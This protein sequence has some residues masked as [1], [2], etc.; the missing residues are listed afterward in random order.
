MRRILLLIPLLVIII[1]V[2][3][4]VKEPGSPRWET[5]VT[6]PI[7]GKIYSMSD[8]IADST[9]PE[10]YDSIGTWF[11][12]S[13][14][15]MFVNY[16]DSIE[17][18][19]NDDSL[20]ADSA[21]SLRS[22]LMGP[23]VLEAP[24]SGT[25]IYLVE[26]LNNSFVPGIYDSIPEFSADSIYKELPAYETFEWMELIA[27][28]D[29][30]GVLAEDTNEVTINITNNCP[31]P[32]DLISIEL[33]G[34]EPNILIYEHIFD[35]FLAS[36][37]SI[38]Y[39]DTL[40]TGQVIDNEM[41]LLVSGHS[42][43]LN[44]PTEITE[45]NNISFDVNLSP[46]TVFEAV[47]EVPAQP[48]DS[49][50]VF[51]VESEDTIITATFK[52]AYMDYQ[53]TDLTGIYNDVT[54]SMPGMTDSNGVA[55]DTT[56]ELPPYGVFY[57]E[58]IPI[59]GYTFTATNN[60]IDVYVDAFIKDSRN[61]Q[62]YDSSLVHITATSG[63]DVTVHIYN[64]Y[65]DDHSFTFKSFE[66]ILEQRIQEIEPT[67]QEI[68]DIPDGLDSIDVAIATLDVTLYS[69]LGAD[70]PVNIEIR[71]YRKDILKE[72]LFK[73]FTLAAGGF[74]NPVMTKVS[75]P[76]AEQI[77]NVVPDK[78]EVAGD[79]IIEG[80]VSMSEEDFNDAYVEGS[81]I[82]YSPMSLITGLTNMQA[83]VDTFTSG[84]DN[85]ILEANLDLNIES[86]VPLDGIVS[87]LGS[88]NLDAFDDSTSTEVDTLFK[89]VELPQ[90]VLNETTGYVVESGFITQQRTLV[91][92]QFELFANA[93]EE[94]PF[95]TKLYI[96]T[97]PT[98]GKVVNF[99]PNDYI[100]VGSLGHFLLDI[101]PEELLGER[102]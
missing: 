33:W 2:G 65:Y 53:I 32:Y 83:K 80:Y 72:T 89:D 52:E 57:A 85:I 86:H 68:E 27:R 20:A 25:A 44:Q 31:F 62:Y 56:F 42:P 45:D 48:Y 4:Q 58:M 14:D 90:A 75:F 64:P 24:G 13:G 5:E 63:I 82:F 76:D 77:F 102:N 101:D 54:F 7:A 21:Y 79:F 88:Y 59:S 71:A 50:W 66:A 51:D 97:Y 100:I 43:G 94:H 41:Y 17:R 37:D 12:A 35:E 1:L 46:M 38:S 96:T 74:E 6:V 26:E 49:L 69:T 60:A 92:S 84:F 9:D 81:Y 19:V 22:V 10:F 39:T 47:A 91:E 55:F 11:S 3:C 40:V 23:L 87:L 70:V 28:Y 99:H 16:G 95:Y 73:T 29:Y 78:I 15:T 98:E 18:V 34:N 36:E 30:T 61:T 93:S 67:S 8:L